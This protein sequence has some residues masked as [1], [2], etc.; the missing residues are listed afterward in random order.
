MPLPP[1][2]TVKELAISYQPLLF[3]SGEVFP[4]GFAAGILHP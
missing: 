4:D 1:I 2:N 3:G